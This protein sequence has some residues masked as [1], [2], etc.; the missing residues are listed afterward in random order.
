MR[1]QASFPFV[2]ALPESIQP[3]NEPLI[4]FEPGSASMRAPMS[5]SA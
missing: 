3:M 2:R 4:E 5:T 1:P